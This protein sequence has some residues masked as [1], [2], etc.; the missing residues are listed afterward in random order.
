MPCSGW[1]NTTKN[2][3]PEPAQGV[4]I[5][6]GETYWGNN[7]VLN[8]AGEVDS[9]QFTASA[10]DTWSMV[11]GYGQSPTTAICMAL[12]P[13]GSTGNNIFFGCTNG[14]AIPA[15]VNTQKLTVAGAYTIVVT[16]TN[17]ATMTYGL[18]LERVSPAPP[19]GM[20]LI[21]NKNVA[22]QV[23]PPTAQDAYT[24]SG[25]TTDTYK[26]TLSDAGGSTCFSVYQPDGTAVVSATCTNGTAIPVVSADVTPTQKGRHVVVVSADGNDSTIN[27]N[28]ELSCLLGSD[29]CKQPPPNCILTDA[30]SYD[31]TSGTLT[32]NF[33]LGTP[34]AV[35][36]NAWLTSQNT[37]Q[38][39]WSVSQPAIEPPASITKTQALAKSGKVGVLSTL[40]IP[41][42]GITCS[43]WA[44]INTGTP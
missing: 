21:L 40:T 3:P 36:W 42:A 43:S 14:T 2:C 25:V 23:T 26:I 13:P 22:A 15:V 17:T 35:T 20:P 31:A 44:P 28:L 30:P 38:S 8:T 1:A 39:L 19:D 18:S 4:P 16:E 27:Y 41:K 7:C 6:S 11:L 33:T 9:F 24:F 37:M 12:L 5:V 34:V 32:M 29:G 10:G